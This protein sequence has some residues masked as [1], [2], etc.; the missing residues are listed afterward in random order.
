MLH[1]TVKRRKR[2]EELVS[3]I[4]ALM[5]D[6]HVK[7]QKYV[8]FSDIKLEQ[9]TSTYDFQPYEQKR[10]AIP[11]EEF[12]LLYNQLNVIAKSCKGNNE[13]RNLQLISPVLW[14][15][16]KIVPGLEI[17]CEEAFFGE[18]ILLR[19]RF[20]FVLY[21]DVHHV[22]LVEAKKE[23]MKQGLSQLLM[24][25][26]VICETTPSKTILGVVSTFDRWDFIRNEPETIY[27]DEGNHIHYEVS[28]NSEKVTINEESL[29]KILEKLHGLLF[30]II[31]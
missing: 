31:S 25:H 20:N 29:R 23:D 24:G 12:K 7:K 11:D 2:L 15:L 26:E 30:E 5:V 3:N 1:L 4:P 14:C 18:S 28:Q 13:A 27:R 16:T 21:K 8:P 10:I 17:S 22:V 19:G 9:I 6:R